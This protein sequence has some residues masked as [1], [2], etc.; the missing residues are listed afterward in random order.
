M[1]AITAVEDAESNVVF[2]LKAVNRIDLSDC[3]CWLH[4]KKN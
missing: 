4:Y 2:D 1:K 3:I